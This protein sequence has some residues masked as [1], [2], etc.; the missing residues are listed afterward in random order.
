MTRRNQEQTERDREG[1][2]APKVLEST[3]VQILFEVQFLMI[4]KRASVTKSD[5]GISGDGHAG[6]VNIQ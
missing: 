3:V 2:W 4:F 6:F 5:L 1:Q